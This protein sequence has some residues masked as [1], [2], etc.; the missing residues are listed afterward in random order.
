MKI[1]SYLGT[2]L[3]ILA[4]I[5]LP[6]SAHAERA[7]GGSVQFVDVNM[8]FSFGG[9]EYGNWYDVGYLDFPGNRGH[10]STRIRRL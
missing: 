10:Q 8:R 6:S 7:W 5:V 9:M 3:L 4:S 2:A 1:K